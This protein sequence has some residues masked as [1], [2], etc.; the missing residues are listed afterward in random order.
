MK[1]LGVFASL[2][3]CVVLFSSQL[4][5]PDPA[6]IESGK[7]SLNGANLLQ[8]ADEEMNKLRFAQ[9]SLIP[10]GAMNSLNPV[11]RIREQLFDVV[12]EHQENVSKPEL[13]EKAYKLLEMVGLKK[14]T[15]QMFPHEL[16]GGLGS[17]SKTGAGK[18]RGN[19]IACSLTRWMH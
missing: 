12:Q 13:E 16:S 14:E 6:R 9:I 11:L 10:Q 15:I 2:R 5:M 17:R 19:T 3:L 8:L 18:K 7:V 1:M 4:S